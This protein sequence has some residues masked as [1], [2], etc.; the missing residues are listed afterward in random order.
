MLVFKQNA[1]SKKTTKFRRPHACSNAW[2]G[3]IQQTLLE[4]TPLSKRTRLSHVALWDWLKV[5]VLENSL[6]SHTVLELELDSSDLENPAV[7]A[8]SLVQNL[9]ESAEFAK[10]N[11]HYIF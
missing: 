6:L 10:N 4:R 9:N 11:Y 2:S 3:D 8:R 1:S 5:V 7:V